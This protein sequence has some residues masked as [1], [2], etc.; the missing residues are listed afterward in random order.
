MTKVTKKSKKAEL[1]AAAMERKLYASEEEA[2]N[3]NNKELY[4]NIMACDRVRA[5]AV[6]EANK[7]AESQNVEVASADQQTDVKAEAK[8]KRSLPKRNK[9]ESK[10]KVQESEKAEEPK[11]D[12]EVVSNV[13]LVVTD[14]KPFREELLSLIRKDC[15][16]NLATVKKSGLQ[17]ANYNK[18]I[19][20]L[21]KS[22]EEAMGKFNSGEFEQENTADGSSVDYV[23]VNVHIVNKKGEV[24]THVLNVYVSRIMDRVEQYAEESKV[25][26]MPKQ[27]EAEPQQESN[28]VVAEEP[29]ADA[30]SVVVAEQDDRS[31]EENEQVNAIVATMEGLHKDNIE[32]DKALKEAQGKI[33][34]ASDMCDKLDRELKVVRKAEADTKLRQKQMYT[35]IISIANQMAATK[36]ENM[37]GIWELLNKWFDKFVPADG[38]ISVRFDMNK[39]IAD[40]KKADE[41]KVDEDT[42]YEG[43]N[44]SFINGEVVCPD[45]VKK[46][47]FKEYK[48]WCDDCKEYIDY[49]I[50]QLDAIGKAKS[51]AKSKELRKELMA[52]LKEW[53]GDWADTCESDVVEMVEETMFGLLN[54]NLSV[55]M[56]MSYLVAIVDELDLV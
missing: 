26:E 1:V 56:A 43:S 50:E 21:N 37:V 35:D 8:A 12:A 17:K 44:V 47:V 2:N 45:G 13:T 20:F 51:K 52:D 7:Q 5:L 55:D 42:D 4:E 39:L 48:A 19:D 3:L 46:K 18:C 22:I 41:G 10:P 49:T 30:E 28:A 33:K 11:A 16:M 38:D 54:H 9:Q 23:P 15:G 24:D 31:E 6:E 27:A 32:K 14:V 25:E 36:D 40:A 53:Y 29:K 34:S